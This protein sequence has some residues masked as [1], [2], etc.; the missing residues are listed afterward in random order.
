MNDFVLE[1]ENDYV[2]F[3][4]IFISF[5]SGNNNSLLVILEVI[6]R[7]YCEIESIVDE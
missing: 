3:F 2:V 1:I 6:L 4:V 5:G 7:E